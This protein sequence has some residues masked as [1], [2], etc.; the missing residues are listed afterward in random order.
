M[1]SKN[2]YESKIHFTKNIVKDIPIKPYTNGHQPVHSS[3]NSIFSKALVQL[4]FKKN[5]LVKNNGKSGSI[6]KFSSFFHSIYK[7]RY[8]PITLM[9][10]IQGSFYDF[11]TIFHL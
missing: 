8:P 11:G 7:K 6:K 9:L 4:R 10:A 1:Q 2:K 5:T 3:H